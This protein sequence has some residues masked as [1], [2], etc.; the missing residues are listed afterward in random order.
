MLFFNYIN[1]TFDLKLF[2][3]SFSYYHLEL[4]I[5]QT[6]FPVYM[7]L[8]DLNTHNCHINI[9]DITYNTFYVK[10]LFLNNKYLFIDFSYVI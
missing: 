5:I 4:I 6:L 8:H 2:R 10:M 3:Q 9:L 7:K 1:Q